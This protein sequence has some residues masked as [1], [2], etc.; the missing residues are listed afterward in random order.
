MKSI[1]TKHHERQMVTLKVGLISVMMSTLAVV[2][3]C[4]GGGGSSDGATIAAPSGSAGPT[5]FYLKRLTSENGVDDASPN[6]SAKASLSAQA[7]CNKL[8]QLE[9]RP[10]APLPDQT[11]LSKI[12]M[13]TIEYWSINGKMKKLV[14]TPRMELVKLTCELKRYTEQIAYIGDAKTVSIVDYYRK[15]VKTAPFPSYEGPR[16]PAQLGPN[17]LSV[18]GEL[19]S[20]QP[21]P[22][23]TSNEFCFWDRLANW[24]ILLNGRETL[25]LKSTAYNITEQAVQIELAPAIPPQTFDIP[26]DFSRI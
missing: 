24:N 22:A 5:I 7:L 19:C 20:V 2:T 1:R 15:T 10:I 8:N 25:T 4:G 21:G 6:S 23:G 3:S 14:T 18:A 26:A 11:G 13:G 16:N 17:K 12:D 9:G